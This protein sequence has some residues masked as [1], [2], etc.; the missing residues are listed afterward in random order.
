MF[1]YLSAGNP[2]VTTPG[3]LSYSSGNSVTLAG[4]GLVNAGVSPKVYV[5][6]TLATVTASSNTAVTFTFP[7]LRQGTYRVS[8]YV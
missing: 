1:T 2:T 6:D 8:V 5:G 7:A 4:L 3:L